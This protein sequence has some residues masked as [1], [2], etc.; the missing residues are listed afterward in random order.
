MLTEET[1]IESLDINEDQVMH[2]RKSTRIFRDGVLIATIYN[3]DIAQPGDDVT[4]ADKKI[5]D[6]AGLL[7]TPKVISDWKEK[8]K[9]KGK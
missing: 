6:I 3:R 8:S 4:V 5:K 2:I 7:W 1:V 9:P